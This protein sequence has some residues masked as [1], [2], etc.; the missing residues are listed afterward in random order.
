MNIKSCSIAFLY[1]LTIFFSFSCGKKEFRTIE[2]KIDFYQSRA[3]TYQ[4]LADAQRLSPPYSSKKSSIKSEFYNQSMRMTYLKEA[5]KYQELAEIAK[6]K[7][8]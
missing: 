1:S 3:K 8:K 4:A 5:K 6:I 7:N 2:Q